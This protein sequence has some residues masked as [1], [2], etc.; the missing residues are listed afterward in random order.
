MELVGGSD[1]DVDGAATLRIALLW[2][3][4]LGK[5][6]RT[7]TAALGLLD[8]ANSGKVRNSMALQS[9]ELRL[10][11]AVHRA[12]HSL[13][14]DEAW[15]FLGAIARKMQ[16]RSMP[17][18]AIAVGAAVKQLAE[19]AP[20]GAFALLAQPDPRGVVVDLLPRIA[21]GIGDTFTDRT[22]RALLAAQPEVLGRLIAE[23][24][25]LAERVSGDA[26]L[27]DR[28]GEVLPQLDPSL[29]DAVG[30]NL[31]PC[32]VA[33]WQLPAAE[34]LLM[35]LDGQGLADEMRHLGLTNDFAAS[36]LAELALERAR[37]IGAR[38]VV[39]SSIAELPAS[40]GRNAMLARTLDPS[41]DDAAWLL[42]NS[43]LSADAASRLLIGLLRKADD[44]QL[45]A[46][47]GDARIGA[48]VIGT[49]E[50][51]ALDLLQR[52]VFVD[53]ISI[54]IF[55]RIVGLVLPTMDAGIKASIA[56]K[57]LRRCLARISGPTS[58][59]LQPQCSASWA[60]GLTAPGPRGLA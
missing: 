14:E 10:A 17:Y 6:E 54:E 4:L 55:V 57:A 45:S 7:P 12:S 51:G 58:R 60:S 26:S 25:T 31:L 11:D 53:G 44:R 9:V 19:R 38:D 56:E 37:K 20:E 36:R 41:I 39:R 52:A 15:D 28:L 34:P 2:D 29:V 1:D 50:G 16:G 8:V 33:D 21:E 43:G 40:E 5:L 48:E 32:L 46:I 49:L 35:R 27:I 47:V 42:H 23:G 3:E 22:E 13:P 24:R 18:G 59:V 30:A